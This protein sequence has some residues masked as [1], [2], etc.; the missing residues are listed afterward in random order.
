[1]VGGDAEALTHLEAIL[2][3]DDPDAPRCAAASALGS[4]GPAAKRSIS[5]LEGLLGDE[6]FDVH[7]AAESALAAIQTRGQ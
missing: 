3:S 1:M 7:Q 2:Q 4:L 6:D 5:V